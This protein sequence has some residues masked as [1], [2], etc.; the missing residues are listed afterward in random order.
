MIIRTTKGNREQREAATR[1]IDAMIDAAIAEQN[2]ERARLGRDLTHDETRQIA[3]DVE[4]ATRQAF[5][6]AGGK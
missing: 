5:A 2:K 1:I 3:D 4:R 6:V